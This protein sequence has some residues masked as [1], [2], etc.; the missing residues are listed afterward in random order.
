MISFI[1][2]IDFVPV[3]WL[4]GMIFALASGFLTVRCYVYLSN[5]HMGSL[6][7]KRGPNVYKLAKAYR[8]GFS[9]VDDVKLRLYYDYIYYTRQASISSFMIAIMLY[10]ATFLL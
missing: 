10:I 1:S 5:G 2:L 6:I 3:L 4:L 8:K 9:Q 7:K